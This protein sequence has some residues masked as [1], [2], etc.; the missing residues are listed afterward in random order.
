MILKWENHCQL[1]SL[2]D[3]TCL[4]WILKLLCNEKFW[5]TFENGEWGQIRFEIKFDFHFYSKTFENGERGEQIKFEIFN[6]F[7]FG[8]I[9]SNL[10]CRVLPDLSK[11]N[12]GMYWL[13][14]RY[15]NTQ[16]D[17]TQHNDTW[18]NSAQRKNKNATLSITTI[19]AVCHY[20]ECRYAECHCVENCYD[21]CSQCY[22]SSYWIL[23][24]WV[25]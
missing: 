20:A 4:G 2:D 8:F 25:S 22:M 7:L 9:N 15:N 1:L 6:A 14:D 21:D 19:D 23:I 13:I 16:H 5:K 10:T 18:Q 24:C 12:T 11:T 17:D 3:S